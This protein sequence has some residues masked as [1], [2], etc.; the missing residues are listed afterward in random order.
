MK[1]KRILYL[2]DLSYQAKGRV[3][4][5]EDIFITGK[6]KESFDVV[7]CHPGCAEG[8]E[9]AADLIVFRNTGSVIGYKETYKSFVNRVKQ[10]GLRTFNTFTGKADM[11]GKEYLL[12]LTAENYPVIPTVDS[13]GCLDMLPET[14]RFVVKPKDGADSIGLEFLTKEELA[15]RDLSGGRFLIQPEIDFDYEVSFY[16]I[17]DK[18]EYALYAPDKTKRWEL[19]QYNCSAEDISFAK[20]FIDWNTIDKGIQRVDACRAKDDRLLLVELED[21]NPYLSLLEVDEKTRDCFMTDFINAIDN[22]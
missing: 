7:L 20:K 12:D 9:D 11:K 10:K 8:F 3:Y 4:C 19:K 5:E 16:F 14:K 13:V 22:A 6:L 17:N 15:T 21:L 1:R 18:L 2:T